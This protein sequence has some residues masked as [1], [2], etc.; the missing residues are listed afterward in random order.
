[1][2]GGRRDERVSVARVT[3]AAE[4]LACLRS[5]FD[6]LELCASAAVVERG[7]HEADGDG[8]RHEDDDGERVHHDAFVLR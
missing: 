7:E 3:Y 5:S 4:R 6:E 2:A 1:V 8:D